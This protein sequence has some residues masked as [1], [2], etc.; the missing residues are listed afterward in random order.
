MTMGK[1]RMGTQL[2]HV[3]E[4]LPWQPITN[5]GKKMTA[6]VNDPLYGLIMVPSL[7][8]F[9]TKSLAVAYIYT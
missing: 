9:A 4:F 7:A 2:V 5:K 3:S 8:C 6:G 1:V